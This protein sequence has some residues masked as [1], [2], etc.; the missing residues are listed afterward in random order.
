MDMQLRTCQKKWQLGHYNVSNY[1]PSVPIMST[2]CG[3]KLHFFCFLWTSSVKNYTLNFM[4]A[5][6]KCD[7]RRTS[8]NALLPM[9]FRVFL[10]QWLF[11]RRK[12]VTERAKMVPLPLRKFMMSETRPDFSPFPPPFFHRLYVTFGRKRKNRRIS[13]IAQ[14]KN[15]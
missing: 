7:N 1:Y 11:F 14:A 3:K 10:Y 6:R 15:P 9:I 8:E 5:T 4:N 2:I 13:R 12:S